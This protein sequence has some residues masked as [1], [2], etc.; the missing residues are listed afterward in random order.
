[1]YFLFCIIILLCGCNRNNSI[2]YNN[3]INDTNI[4]YID[5][6]IQEQKNL[7]NDINNV[8][9]ENQKVEYNELW[10]PLK[11]ITN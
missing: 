8:F 2:Q 3:V 1:M 10:E 4:N 11:T 5:N 9:V 6:E 7:E